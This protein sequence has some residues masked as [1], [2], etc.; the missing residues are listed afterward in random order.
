ML[1]SSR[2]LAFSNVEADDIRVLARVMHRIAGECAEMG[3]EIARV[4]EALSDGLP[5]RETHLV[6]FQAF[7]RLSQNAHAQA[8][9][10]AHLARQILLGT[11]TERDI[12]NQIEEIPLPDIRARM[13]QTV[14]NDCAPVIDVADEEAVFWTEQLEMDGGAGS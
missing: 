2:A 3:S 13:R 12:V 14:R 9:L 7:D 6:E 4:G 1:N 10:V 5:N 11:C 8:R